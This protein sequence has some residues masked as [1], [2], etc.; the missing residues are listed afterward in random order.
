MIFFIAINFESNIVQRGFI[1]LEK[2][3]SFTV[4]DS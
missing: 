2:N 3:I 1:F 4:T